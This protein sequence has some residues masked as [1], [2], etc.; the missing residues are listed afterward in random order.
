MH[1]EGWPVC[2]AVI[3]IIPT[4]N[5]SKQFASL[6]QFISFVAMI[7]FAVQLLF[8]RSASSTAYSRKEKLPV[9]IHGVQ[10]TGMDHP[11]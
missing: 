5:H 6:N 11:R 8:I 4:G 3:S 9:S 1:Y 10:Y 2:R 7:V